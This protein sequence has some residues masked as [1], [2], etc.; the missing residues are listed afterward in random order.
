MIVWDD[1]TEMLTF[2]GVPVGAVKENKTHIEL[3]V[4]LARILYYKVYF[5]LLHS[6][7]LSE[8]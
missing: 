2:I 1:S 4:F 7:C 3:N 6:S 8:L 5:H